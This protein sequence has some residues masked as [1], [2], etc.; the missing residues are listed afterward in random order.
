MEQLVEKLRPLTTFAEKK[1]LADE[2]AWRLRFISSP[3]ADYYF[4]AWIYDDGDAWLGACRTESTED[5]YFW[6]TNFELL[7][8]DSQEELNQQLIDNVTLL[9]THETQIVQTKGLINM[10]FFLVYHADGEWQSLGGNGGLRVGGFRFPPITGKEQV[11]Q[12]PAALPRQSL[13]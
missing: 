12:A 2:T 5:E 4:F 6:S 10:G 3:D 1:Q 11:Y 8:Y 13:K 7:V 9:L